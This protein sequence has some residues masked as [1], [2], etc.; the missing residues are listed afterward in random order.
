MAAAPTTPEAIREVNVRYHDAAA[1]SYDAKWG[2]DLGPVGQAQV[3][4][5]VRK[6]LGSRGGRDP[7]FDHSLEIGAGTGYFTLN[8]VQAGVVR[9]ATASDISPGMLDALEASADRLGVGPVVETVAADATALPFADSSFDLVLGHAVLHHVPDLATAFAEFHRV[10]HPGGTL[11]FAGEPSRLG[12][13]IAAYPKRAA[14]R[15]APAWRRAL[16][17]RPGHGFG[18][19]HRGAEA[20]EALE[21]FVD[22]HSFTPE[23]LAGRARAAGFERVRVRGEELLANWFGWT[24]RTLEASARAEDIPWLWTQYAYRGYLALQRVDRLLLEPR[25]PPAF[26]YNLMVSARRP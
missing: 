1:R 21:A 24:N 10:L 3:L 4:G 14:L 26:F 16:R 17:L 13:R 8:L 5:K 19:E 25:M 18:E 6:A 23:D 2:V 15:A 7:I 22:V 20:D 12:D 9:R 11:V